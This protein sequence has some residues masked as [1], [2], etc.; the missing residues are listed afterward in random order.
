MGGKP[1][2]GHVLRSILGDLALTLHLSGI[3]DIKKENLNRS[4][5]R[6]VDH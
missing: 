5:L 2:V 4:V 6:R 3:T 1:G